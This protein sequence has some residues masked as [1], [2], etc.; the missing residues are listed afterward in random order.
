M[1]CF[2][3]V[4][5]FFFFFH[6]EFVPFQVTCL[7][8]HSL[9]A[10]MGDKFHIFNANSVDPDQKPLSLLTYLSLHCQSVSLLWDAKHKLIKTETCCMYIT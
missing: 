1:K 3:V 4:V 9:F 8:V 6:Y 2:F 5:F 10:K 7:F